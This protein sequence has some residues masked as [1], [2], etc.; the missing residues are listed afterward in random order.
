MENENII[1]VRDD[2]EF[3]FIYGVLVIKGNVF[4]IKLLQ[5]RIRDMREKLG[6][7]DYNGDDIVKKVINKYNEYKDTKYISYN[8][9]DL[10]V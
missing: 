3:E 7:D 1:L 10:E 6:Y 9:Y 4:D 2:E 8:N 5:Q